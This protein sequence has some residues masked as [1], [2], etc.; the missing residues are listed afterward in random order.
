MRDL[1]EHSRTRLTLDF[2]K[3]DFGGLEQTAVGDDWRAR[4]AAGRNRRLSSPG[5]TFATSTATTTTHPCISIWT[6]TP[7]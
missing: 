1:V 4:R 6:R 2:S 3:A 5:D 7:E